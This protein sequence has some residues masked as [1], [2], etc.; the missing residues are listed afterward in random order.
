[1]ASLEVPR[2]TVAVPKVVLQAPQRRRLALFELQHRP[3]IGGR[4]VDI[5][6]PRQVIEG[7]HVVQGPRARRDRG[8]GQHPGGQRGEERARRALVLHLVLEGREH[9]GQVF[10][11]TPEWDVRHVVQRG[12]PCPHETG[13]AP[14]CR[15]HH[16]IHGAL[17][18]RD[19]FMRDG[20]RL[21]RQKTRQHL[22]RPPHD[23]Q[24]VGP[25]AAEVALQVEHRVEEELGAEGPGLGAPPRRHARY[26]GVGEVDGQ[27]GSKL[28]L[29]HEVHRLRQHGIVVQL[30]VVG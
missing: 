25:H 8:Q 9:L 4:T 24:N 19:R 10:E 23:H 6:L 12:A 21:R 26:A 27:D 18:A 3:L 1:M 20:H 14:Q 29:S 30:Q 22:L 13:P 7:R 16:P 28:P 11:V 5:R 15:L 2:D 17:L